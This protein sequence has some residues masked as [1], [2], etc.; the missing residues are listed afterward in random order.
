MGLFDALTKSVGKKLSSEGVTKLEKGMVKLIGSI[1]GR[2]KEEVKKAPNPKI[3]A[4]TWIMRDKDKEI[5]SATYGKTIRLRIETEEAQNTQILICISCDNWKKDYINII[6]TEEKVQNKNDKKGVTISSFSPDIE[7]VKDI[8]VEKSN[9]YADVYLFTCN[10]AYWPV[11]AHEMI[12]EKAKGKQVNQFEYSSLRFKNQVHILTEANKTETIEL[13][14]KYEGYYYSKDGEYLGK[15]GEL[16]D[17]YICDGKKGED[18][19]NP[20][21]LKALEHD[22]SNEVFLRIAGL[23]YGETGYNA[24]AIKVL[25]YAIMNHQKQLNNSKITKYQK[26]TWLLPQTLQKMRGYSDVSYAQGNHAFRVFMGISTMQKTVTSS[27]I[28]FE[29]NAIQRNT[30]KTQGYE[31]MKLAIKSVYEGIL[32]LNNGGSDIARNAIGWHGR[33]IIDRVTSNPDW[34]Q[35]LYVHKTEQLFDFKSK[36]DYPKAKYSWENYHSHKDFGNETKMDVE[37]KGFDYEVGHSIFESVLIYE[38]KGG[39]GSTLFYKSTRYA[40]KRDNYNVGGIN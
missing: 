7:W 30:Y 28:D 33:D 31:L 3:S 9:I 2:E 36:K 4:V 32:Y 11:D 8:N 13:S 14:T 20:I 40:F 21:Q 34:K 39:L 38:G 6:T 23:A 12:A 22:I 26:K 29:K 15:I 18:Y 19:R 17:V 25:P 10:A 35:I 1:E 5:N 16:D 24:E 37:K 27:D